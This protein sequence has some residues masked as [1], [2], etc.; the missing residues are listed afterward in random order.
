MLIRLVARNASV[1]ETA[2]VYQNAFEHEYE[3]R[4]AEHE[5]EKMPE[6]SDAT[7]LSVMSRLLNN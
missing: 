2:S 5:H 7:E 4:R 3:H 1:S 6:Q